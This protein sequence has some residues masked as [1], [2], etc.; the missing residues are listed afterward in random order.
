MIANLYGNPHSTSVASQNTSKRVE[1]ARLRLLELF[2]ANPE[3][4]DLVFVANATAGIKLV[5]DAFRD[6]ED[7]FWYGYHR[8]A[9]TSLVGVREAAQEH[10]CFASD[11]EFEAWLERAEEEEA[12]ERLRLVAY[13]AQSN[14]NG[15]R[16]PLQWC[17]TARRKQRT[18]TLLDAAALVS[19][20][21]LD[22]SDSAS[23]PD[24]TVMSL[25]KIF[26][27]PDLGALIVRK[28]S[29]N[30]L[31]KRRY[32]G[33]GTVDMVVCMSEQWHTRKT[34]SIHDALEDGTLPIHSIMAL[35]AALDV[36]DDLFGPL[37][38]VSEHCAVLAKKLHG[39][40]AALRHGNGSPVC[41][42]Y[43]DARSDYANP[44]TQG[45]IVVFNIRDANGSWV[46]NSEV[47][48]MAA[49]RNIQLRTGGLCNPGGIASQLQLEP[50]EMKRNFSA[51][52]R[53]GQE[54]DVMH[55]KPTGMIRLSVGAMSTLADI[56]ALVSFMQ[57]FF[58]EQ[59]LPVIESAPDPPCEGDRWYVESLTV[60]PI[61]S[62][63][64]YRIPHQV[65]WHTNPEGLAWDRE[66]CLV[67]PGTGAALSQKRYPRMA[68]IRPM[69]DLDRGLM[70]VSFADVRAGIPSI[71]IPLSD[72]PS[73][74]SSNVD[75]RKRNAI[76]CGDTISARTYQSPAVT[77]FFT[78][79]LGVRCQLARFPA[80]GSSRHAKA[81][82]QAFQQKMQHD[83][84]TAC[85]HI[86]GSFPADDHMATEES[87]SKRPIL[88]SNESPIL[89]ISR[90]SLNRLNEQIKASGGKAVHAEAFRANIVVAEYHRVGVH[91]PFQDPYS[92]D[93]WK[94]VRIGKQHFEIMGACRRCQMVC[95]DQETGERTQEPF[96]TLAKTRRY[97][98]K[99]YFGQHACHVQILQPGSGDAHAS[100]IKVGEK[101]LPYLGI[102]DVEPLP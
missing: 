66:W 7:G 32:F 1:D 4:Y 20:T 10:V 52:L 21:P 38:R 27:F 90:S 59:R 45:P 93:H 25:Y 80:S 98:G 65:R 30:V 79:A 74:F 31:M 85:H 86:P 28:D 17:P 94:Y 26:G 35:H 16:L 50:W 14:M 44:A 41:E 64:G 19:T 95:I 46:A 6:A 54:G 96:S 72:D 18:F 15:R 24:F 48:K 101:V 62:C 102:G 67:Q 73:M 57:E 42:F 81:H 77:E 13:P 91:G 36:H 75:F 3:D 89:I 78:K 83:P 70:R 82:L 8:D 23:A 69:I 29:G 37:K 99:V 51:G 56:D 55:G 53:C 33:G 63:A 60:F 71:T 11:E 88:L 68:L 22:L 47:D 43:T 76:V 2:S 9:H 40:L 12:S 58:V 92:E 97:G 49:V 61:K 34:E 39:D 5:M 84:L 87:V 100:T